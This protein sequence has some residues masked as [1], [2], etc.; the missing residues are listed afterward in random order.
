[1]PA[2]EYSGPELPWIRD[3]YLAYFGPYKVNPAVGSFINQVEASSYRPWIGSTQY[4]QYVV[5]GNECVFSV[6]A[7]GY[8]HR[9]TWKRAQLSAN[10]AA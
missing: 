2:R 5:K 9:I 6:S 7:G 3:G 10:M 4:R 8:T 1:M